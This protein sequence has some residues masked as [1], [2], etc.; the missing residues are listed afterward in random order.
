MMARILYSINGGGM[1]HT[2]RSIPI[3]RALRKKHTVCIIISSQRCYDVISKL[4]PDVTEVSGA[5][6]VY[7]YNKVSDMKT[8]KTFLKNIW[9]EGPNNVE[10]LMKIFREYK[11]DIVITDFENTVLPFAA[12]FRVPVICLCN[13][14]A[15]TEFR[16]KVPEKHLKDYVMA[17]FVIRTFFSGIDYHLISSFFS[18]PVRR[19]NVFTFPPVLRD[20]VFKAKPSRKDYVLVYQTSR[21]NTA[22]LMSLKRLKTRFIIY[23]FDRDAV[24]GNL[25]FKKFRNE[26]FITDLKDCM[27]CIANGGYT[28]ISEA[29]SLHKPVLSIPI[30]GQFEQILNAL[31]IQK[32][33]YG[34]YHENP[35]MKIIEKFID[36]I[37]IYYNNLRNYKKHDN[38]KILKKL[39]QLIKKEV[40]A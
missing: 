19:K 36:S 37:E 14:H 1:G 21:T 13:V 29:L 27:A 34:E 39:D 23:G 35:S 33:G 28:F 5:K 17:N 4:F 20:E 31:M 16:Y 7:R 15:V 12:I 26:E 10:K 6:F 24:Q 25:T 30:Q 18:M 38:K 11:P 2:F 9:K 3:I 8:A 22:L 40:N 32:L